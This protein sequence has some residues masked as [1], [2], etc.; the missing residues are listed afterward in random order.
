MAQPPLDPA[1]PFRLHR[2]GRAYS[3]V[4]IAIRRALQPAQGIGQ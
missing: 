3:A 2:E 4:E 1:E